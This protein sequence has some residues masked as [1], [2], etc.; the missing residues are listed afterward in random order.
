MRVLT[1]PAA[2]T[3]VG[4]HSAAVLGLVWYEVILILLYQHLIW[5][6]KKE[7]LFYNYKRFEPPVVLLTVKSTSYL[8]AA[9]TGGMNSACEYVLLISATIIWTFTLVSGPMYTAS[10]IWH[11][12][13]LQRSTFNADCRALRVSV[14]A[15]TDS[16][17]RTTYELV[18]VCSRFHHHLSSLVL[19]CVQWVEHPIWL[20]YP[21]RDRHIHAH[22]QPEANSANSL[23]W[24][25]AW[26]QQHTVV[27]SSACI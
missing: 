24:I 23:V 11:M 8:C 10:R 3:V 1:P 6:W 12:Q 7:L 26:G 2:S 4:L 5:H 13:A 14:N 19:P 20:Y 17:K 9:Y 15:K 18:C 25:M 21:V 27:S 16:T 22:P